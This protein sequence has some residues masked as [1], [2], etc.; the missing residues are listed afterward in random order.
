M[1]YDLIG[2]TQG[3]Q[4]DYVLLASAIEKGSVCNGTEDEQYDSTRIH[5]DALHNSVH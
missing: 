1:N 4:F 2:T 5:Y 3:D